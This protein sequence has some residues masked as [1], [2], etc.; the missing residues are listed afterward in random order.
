VGIQ[1]SGL[2]N[3][4]D[5]LAPGPDLHREVLKRRDNRE[6]AMERRIIDVANLYRRIGV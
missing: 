5:Q 3:L 4:R 6:W 1:L 2:S